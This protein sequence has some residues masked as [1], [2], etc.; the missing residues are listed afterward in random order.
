MFYNLFNF[1]TISKRRHSLQDFFKCRNINNF[2]KVSLK[3]SIIYCVNCRTLLL[4]YLDCQLNIGHIFFYHLCMDE[5]AS[6]K[7]LKVIIYGTI[8]NSEIYFE[9]SVFFFTFTF[10]CKRTCM[11]VVT[12]FQ[13]SF[14][15]LPQVF[16][17]CFIFDL[18]SNQILFATQFPQ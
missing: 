18:S 16:L 6:Y 13:V 9:S 2:P 7:P 3:E 17:I 14:W 12:L 10:I 8:S 1:V 11:A 15:K 4:G 5:L